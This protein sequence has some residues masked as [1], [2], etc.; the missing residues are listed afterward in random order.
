MRQPVLR[1]DQ[2]ERIKD[3]LLGKQGDRGATAR[4]NRRFLEAVLWIARTGTP[5]RDLPT[6]LGHWYRVYVR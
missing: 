4:D 5:W 3:L 1:N 6:S 2:W